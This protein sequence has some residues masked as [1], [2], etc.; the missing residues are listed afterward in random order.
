M[1]G[2][3]QTRGKSSD[4]PVTIPQV[5]TEQITLD[6]LHCPVERAVPPM[7]TLK[8]SGAAVFGGLQPK[9]GIQWLGIGTLDPSVERYI[10]T[11]ATK[12]MA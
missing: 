4:H 12:E 2:E 5:G 6:F 9:V 8:V 11:S 3:V 10:A 7:V 1:S